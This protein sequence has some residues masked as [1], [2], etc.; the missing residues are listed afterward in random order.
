MKKRIVLFILV[1]MLI[2]LSGCD[3]LG[4]ANTKSNHM[5]SSSWDKNELNH[6]HRCIEAGYGDLKKDEAPHTFEVV[7]QIEATYENAGYTIMECSV[8]GYR[9]ETNYVHELEHNYSSAYNYNEY[10]HYYSCTDP[11]YEDLMKDADRHTFIETTVEASHEHGGYVSHECSVCHY[12]YK[13]DETHQIPYVITWANDDG[14][15]LDTDYYMLNGMPRYSGELPEKTNPSD[16]YVYTFSGWDKEITKATQDITYTA[17]YEAKKAKAYVIYLDYKDEVVYKVA[18]DNLSEAFYHLSDTRYRSDDDVYSYQFRGWEQLSN[19]DGVIVFKEKFEKIPLGL[20][21]KKGEVVSYSGSAQSIVIPEE[22]NGY[23]VTKILEDAFENS[24]S[25]KSITIPNSIIEIEDYAFEGCSGLEN[26]IIPEGVQNIGYAVLRGCTSITSIDMPQLIKI[27][28]LFGIKKSEDYKQLSLERVVVRKSYNNTSVSYLFGNCSTI[29]TVEFKDGITVVPSYC[30]NE[31]SSLEQVILPDTISKINEYAFNNCIA[32]KTIELPSS[33]TS[34]GK[35]AFSNCAKLEDIIIPDLVTKLEE[36]TFSG[37][38]LLN[39]FKIPS[40]I[41]S[42]GYGAFDGCVKILNQYDNGYYIGDE[43]TDYAYFVKAVDSGITSL[44]INDNCKIIANSVLNTCKQIESLTVPFIGTSNEANNGLV[45]IFN[46]GDRSAPSTL[47]TLI[48]S[49][50]CKSIPDNA[51]YYCFSI[52]NLTIPNSVEKI[53]DNAFYELPLTC[54]SYGNGLYI[55][56]EENNYLVLVDVSRSIIYSLTIHDDC[57]FI[58]DEG[59]DIYGNNPNLNCI[60]FGMLTYELKGNE[61]AKFSSLEKIT[62]SNNNPFYTVKNNMLLNKDETKVYL[63]VK[64]IN[65]GITIPSTVKTIGMDAFVGGNYTSIGF[66]ESLE[67]INVSAFAGCSNLKSLNIPSSVEIIGKSAFYSC[68]GLKSLSVPS[69]VKEIGKD[70]FAYCTGLESITVSSNLIDKLDDVLYVY[71]RIYETYY[72]VFPSSI[73]NI[74][75]DYLDENSVFVL[76]YDNR[77]EVINIGANVSVIPEGLFKSFAQLKEFN[78]DDNNT[79]YKAINGILYDINLTTL[80]GVPSKYSGNLDICSTVTRIGDYAFY[81]YSGNESIVLNQN[82]TEIGKYA[83]G[84]AEFKNIEISN[85]VLTIEDHAFCYSDIESI[86]IPDSVQTI[87]MSAFIGCSVL[88]SMVLPYVGGS[89]TENRYLGYIFGYYYKNEFI[90]EFPESF[91]QLEI[92]NS[93]TSLAIDSFKDNNTLETIYIGKD[94]EDIPYYL[95]ND[96]ESLKSITVS[97]LNK[98]YTSKNGILYDKYCTKLLCCP[99]KLEGK[100]SIEN[101]VKELDDFAFNGRTLVTEII[102]PMNLEKIGNDVFTNCDSLTY[103]EFDGALYIGSSSKPYLI[104]VKGKEDAVTCTVHGVCKYLIPGAFKNC[105]NLKKIV[106][107]DLID[108]IGDET[109]NGCTSLESIVIPSSVLSIGESAF[110]DCS[111]L[112][113][114]SIPDSVELIGYGAFYGCSSLESIRVPFIGESEEY[115]TNSYLGFIFGN[116]SNR[117]ANYPNNIPSSLVTL[118]LGGKT[119]NIGK[120]SFKDCDLEKIYLSDSVESLELGAISS[121]TSF[122]FNE[123][124]DGKYIGTTDNPYYCLYETNDITVLNVHKDCKII[125]IDYVKYFPHYLR[126]INVPEDNTRYASVD[127]VL[128]SKDMTVLLLC[129]VRKSG[130]LV[131]PEGVETIEEDRLYNLE[132]K[133]ISIPSTVKTIKWSFISL[134]NTDFTITISPLNNYYTVE[135]GVLYNKNMT[136]LICCMND[137]NYLEVPDTVNYIRD[138]A[139]NHMSILKTIVIGNNVNNFESGSDYV[140]SKYTTIVLN[141]NIDNASLYLIDLFNDIANTKGNGY[142]IV[143]DDCIVLQ[144][145]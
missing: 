34:I 98:K 38:V 66:P 25:L 11:G 63:S 41:T 55:G 35:Y 28:F 107:N 57:R 108:L 47:K 132:S 131:I 144:I 3:L 68:S 86:V 26:I 99:R 67:E 125:N 12:S 74:N 15:I 83:F 27:E 135:N 8:C 123:Y 103:N 141:A 106:L 122:I 56:N 30:F 91:K 72:H 90:T 137:I 24:T 94:L 85:G 31:C 46:D 58:S 102:L 7:Y 129:P 143:L 110:Y 45:Y 92:S 116:L 19:Q 82:I 77:V 80:L 50:K 111:S 71:E 140:F 9:L 52:T 127:G 109:F 113:V 32:L 65:G 49:D 133:N 100:V 104:L 117:P 145:G 16:G 101:S 62:V 61:F 21:I 138:Y 114:I 128:Y 81:N 2:C 29:K 39:N 84:S 76:P 20:S 96:I 23:I 112:K 70:A 51:F 97:D 40:A 121:F 120:S 69:S 89:S 53:G 64:K 33:I 75:I 1:L 93:C 5:Y 78:V 142:V 18:S 36:G 73:K 17:V 48:L 37:C 43:E 119:K 6:W 4:G 79:N 44:V 87:G 139:F 60:N 14:S 136:E 22:Y 10:L 115:N 130:A 13:T 42:I 134:Y 126:E 124:E 88:E 105:V 118:Y 95:F 54:Y 59:F